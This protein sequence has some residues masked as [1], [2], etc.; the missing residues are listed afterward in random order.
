M[1]R[2]ATFITITVLTGCAVIGGQNYHAI[3]DVDTNYIDCDAYLGETTTGIMAVLHAPTNNKVIKHND[4]DVV[5]CS[6]STSRE[7]MYL[8]GVLIPLIPTF[9]LGD[10]HVPNY[11]EFSINNRSKNKVVR[12]SM[13]K[14]FVSC[15]IRKETFSSC[16]KDISDKSSIPIPSGSILE[17]EVAYKEQISFDLELDDGKVINLNFT[18]ESGLFFF[19]GV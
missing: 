3:H 10:D 13:N 17:L 1:H 8:F 7:S 5:I 9:G 2:L 6:K 16:N 15:F 4:N 11:V 14:E 18:D 19:L 12:F